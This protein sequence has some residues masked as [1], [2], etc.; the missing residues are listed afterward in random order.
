M[1]LKMGFE[2]P[3]L[4]LPYHLQAHQSGGTSATEISHKDTTFGRLKWLLTLG[5]KKNL[6]EV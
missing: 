3:F 5:P 6:R 2:L 4:I 1:Y